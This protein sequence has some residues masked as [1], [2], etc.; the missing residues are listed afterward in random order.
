MLSARTLHWQ[1]Q[2]LIG[3]WYCHQGSSQRRTM[4]FHASCSG[5]GC[6][7]ASLWMYCQNGRSS[8]TAISCS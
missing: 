2:A 5:R 6:S 8:R 4:P 7:T 1:P 3:K